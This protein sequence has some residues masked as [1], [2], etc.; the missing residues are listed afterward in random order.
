MTK[1][2][3]DYQP[4]CS[5]SAGIPSQLQEGHKNIP[6]REL[7]LTVRKVSSHF[8]FKQQPLMSIQL[9]ANR[10]SLRSERLATT[11][12]KKP[13]EQPSPTLAVSFSHPSWDL[14]LQRTQITVPC[15][16]KYLFFYTTPRKLVSLLSWTLAIAAKFLSKIAKKNICV[17]LPSFSSSHQHKL[18]RPPVLHRISKKA[19][20]LIIE[21][22]Q[23]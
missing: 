7:Q 1:S 10:W 4:R 12:L 11:S 2:R 8:L 6:G 14:N 18:V 15:P 3:N 16:E 23:Y 17:F 13:L 19:G 21:A 22:F 5:S 9:V 20:N